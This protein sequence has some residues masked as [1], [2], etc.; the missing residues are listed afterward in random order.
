QL[1]YF[2]NG[3]NDAYINERGAN[4]DEENNY[5]NLNCIFFIFFYFP[6]A[7]SRCDHG[8]VAL[9]GFDYQSIFKLTIGA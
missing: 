3:Y 7:K 8:F 5:P 1:S 9:N 2:C 4:I 6:L